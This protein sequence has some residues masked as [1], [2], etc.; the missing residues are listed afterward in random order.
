MP[1]GK[2][3]VPTVVV[4]LPA[5]VDA[6][7]VRHVGERLAEAMAAGT[8]V[9]IADMTATMSCDARGAHTLAVAHR[10]AV[11]GGMG[12]RVV[13]ATWSVRRIFTI[14]GLDDVLAIYPDLPSAQAAPGFPG[15]G[16]P[17]A[18]AAGS[19]APDAQDWSMLYERARATRRRSTLLVEQ[20]QILCLGCAQLRTDRVRKH[21][22]RPAGP[23]RLTRR[24]QTAAEVERAK[25]MIMAATGYDKSQAAEVLRHASRALNVPGTDLATWIV[26]RAADP[27]GE[28]DPD[29]AQLAHRR[30][31][32][33]LT[34]PPRRG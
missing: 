14:T 7:T 3:P 24:L 34:G 6:S 18:R 15:P 33:R 26:A 13:V 11:L 25:G 4:P 19:R 10:R 8:T 21:L 29:P 20:S 31:G 12:L 32:R 17:P 5:R 16:A 22:L 23:S 27:A 1:E 30:P 9:V 28:P 2:S